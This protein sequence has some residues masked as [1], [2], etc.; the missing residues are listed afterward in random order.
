MFGGSRFFGLCIKKIRAVSCE[1]L[2]IFPSNDDLRHVENYQSKKKQ[3]KEKKLGPHFG[4]DLVPKDGKLQSISIL[5]EVNKLSSQRIPGSGAKGELLP[6]YTNPVRAHPSSQRR[7]ARLKAARQR[8]RRRRRSRWGGWWKRE[9]RKDD[10]DRQ[11]LIELVLNSGRLCL[12][13]L[14]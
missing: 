6:G 7:P 13:P 9:E 12:G 8:R 5:Q 10:R 2:N 14:H 1:R 3:Q 11:R 4:A